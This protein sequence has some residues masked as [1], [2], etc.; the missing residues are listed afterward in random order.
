[1][2]SSQPNMARSLHQKHFVQYFYSEGTNIAYAD[3]NCTLVYVSTITTVTSDLYSDLEET[4]NHFKSL[5]LIFIRGIMLNIYFLQYWYIQITLRVPGLSVLITFDT[6]LVY[7]II[8]MIPY[9]FLGSSIN[10]KRIQS[11]SRR[12]VCVLWTS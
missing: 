5:K 10:T 3:S 7:L 9:L 8:I 2:Y 4:I 12:F 6:S 1:M 11:L